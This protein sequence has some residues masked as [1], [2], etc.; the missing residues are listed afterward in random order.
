MDT[1]DADKILRDAWQRQV[2]IPA[3][4]LSCRPTRREEGYAVQALV[5]NLTSAPLFGWKIAATSKAGQAHVGVAGPMAGRLLKE[6]V[7]EPHQPVRLHNNLMSV[8]EPEFA[9][10]MGN[11]LPPTGQT[12]RVEEVM[13]AVQGLH[14]AIEIPD[15][16]FQRFESAGEAQ[17]I[18]DNACA[19]E[20]VLG[21][22]VQT[23][24]RSVDLAQ[25]VVKADVQGLT[26]AYQRD[27][28]GSNVLGDPRVA[29][30]WLANELSSLGITLR[31]GQVITTGT[32][33]VPLEVLPGDQVHVDYGAFGA[34]AVHFV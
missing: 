34:M 11:D 18:A 32:C 30:T 4:P 19:H 17:L 3:L 2:Q 20:F 9:F 31:A 22:A 14:L 26:R 15:S 21:P 8:A 27:G 24:W 7:I 28:I 25:H 16:R 13:G 29:L 5:E 10:V 12:Y 1:A 23:D 33:M 6:R